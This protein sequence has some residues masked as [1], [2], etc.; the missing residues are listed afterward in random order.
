MCRFRLAISRFAL[1]DSGGRGGEEMM[2]ARS[3]GLEM[4]GAL[5]Y[6]LMEFVFFFQK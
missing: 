1:P 6:A 2:I 3:T 5:I 4:T